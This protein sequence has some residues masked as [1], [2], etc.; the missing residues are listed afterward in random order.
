MS[1]TPS[2]K[3]PSSATGRIILFIA[4]FCVSILSNGCVANRSYRRGAEVTPNQL[5]SSIGLPDSTET[6]CSAPRNSC[7]A[8]GNGG[9]KPR[10]FYLS[11]IEF[12]DMGELWSI[13]D[14]SSSTGARPSTV[15]PSQ[16]ESAVSTIRAAKKEAE[17][18]HAKVLVITFIHGWHNNASEYDEKNKN[19]AG[20]KA[21]LQQLSYP[22]SPT[23]PN[24]PPVVVGIFVAWRGQVVA[25][26]VFTS[27]WNRRDVATIVGGP[28]MTEV[29]TRLMFE[30]KGASTSPNPQDRCRQQVLGPQEA[31]DA[32][33]RFLIIGHS[34]GARVLEEAIGQPMLAL[35]LERQAQAE[36]CVVTW[37]QQHRDEAPLQSVSFQLPA[38]M[39][40]FLN[41]ANGALQTKAIIEAFKRSHLCGTPQ[42]VGDNNPDGC[43]DFSFEGPLMISITSEGDWATGK[44]MPLAQTLSIPWK[45]FRKYDDDACSLGELGYHNQTWYFRHNDGNVSEMRSHDVLLKPGAECAKDGWPYFTTEESGH[46]RC[47]KI[48]TLA[49]EAADKSQLNC[50]TNKTGAPWNNTP[51]F[52]MRVPSTLIADHNDIFQDGTIKLLKTVLVHYLSDLPRTI[53]APSPSANRP[54]SKTG[55]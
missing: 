22:Q 2:S 42:T 53:T 26:D 25:G 33:S 16:L 13:G 37:N 47:F 41:P 44:V 3:T 29:I 6:D 1:L 46:K 54:L 21:I 40:V 51:F 11:Y 24:Q 45:A 30:T 18:R 9:L 38:D 35:L 5:P 7:V 20:F 17:S 19:L 8:D 55:Q 27:Y 28:S 48:E 32:N 31:M 50:P 36:S 23:D 52:V 15:K 34:F 49:E 10:H 39:V 12:D 4:A 43:R 14:L